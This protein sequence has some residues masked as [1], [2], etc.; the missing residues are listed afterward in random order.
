LRASQEM[1]L[2]RRKQRNENLA[3]KSRQRTGAKGRSSVEKMDKENTNFLQG[4]QQTQKKA[5]NP[6]FE[7]PRNSL[8]DF[9]NSKGYKQKFEKSLVGG[10]L[11][12]GVHKIASRISSID[13]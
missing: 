10:I 8:K 1:N 7:L 4:Q 13:K 12:E 5:K 6:D 9:A 2:E 3:L 11:Q